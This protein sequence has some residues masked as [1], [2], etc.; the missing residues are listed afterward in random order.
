MPHGDDVSLEEIGHS[1]KESEYYSPLK[2]RSVA[3]DGTSMV[4]RDELSI[5]GTLS[6]RKLAKALRDLTLPQIDQ[7]SPEPVDVDEIADISEDMPEVQV[8][9][10]VEEKEEEMAS[11]PVFAELDGLDMDD[12]MGDDIV[13]E[14]PPVAS[15]VLP[16]DEE[17]KVEAE[18]KGP[19]E[20]LVFDELEGFDEDDMM[21]GF[22]ADEP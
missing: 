4:S 19:A 2:L 8:E 18:N 17:V 6:P 5:V 20:A 3:N 12:P 22:Q 10:M 9:D 16:I 15:D 14:Q 7:E 11:M 13:I 21:M 1:Y